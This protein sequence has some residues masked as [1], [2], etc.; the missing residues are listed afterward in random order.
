MRQKYNAARRVVE[1]AIY[2]IRF[3]AEVD[4][5]KI[6]R[7]EAETSAR[8]EAEMKEKA[9]SMRKAR[10]EKAKAEASRLQGEF[11]YKWPN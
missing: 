5:A 10:G 8:V 1:E 2:E 9:E 7:A 4:I 3:R 6:E 11:Y